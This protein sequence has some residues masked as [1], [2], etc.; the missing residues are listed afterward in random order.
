VDATLGGLHHGGLSTTDPER[1]VT[2]Y[3][4]VLGAVM[5]TRTEL[6]SGS[7]DLLDIGAGQVLEIRQTRMLSGTDHIALT[8]ADHMAFLGL[9]RRLLDVG[10]SDGVVRDAGFAWILRFRDPDQ[11]PGDLVLVRAH[12]PLAQISS[13]MDWPVVHPL[14]LIRP[15]SPPAVHSRTPHPRQMTKLVSE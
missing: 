8:A 14:E 2:F 13:P 12:L 15:S 11:R 1:L 7:V 10:A 6:D 9:R 5:V 4:N 3:V